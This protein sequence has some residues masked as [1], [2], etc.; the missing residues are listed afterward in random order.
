M[1]T[2][3]TKHTASC[4]MVFGNPRPETGCP[5]CAELANGSPARSWSISRRRADDAAR[6]AEI[7]RHNCTTS[8]CGTVCTAFDW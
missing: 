7:R 8:R 6:I 1:T 3:A 2:T 4:T 5:R